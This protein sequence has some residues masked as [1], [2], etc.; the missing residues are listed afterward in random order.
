V[1]GGLHYLI[2]ICQTFLQNNYDLFYL[3][4]VKIMLIFG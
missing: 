3:M 2:P 1:R 4:K